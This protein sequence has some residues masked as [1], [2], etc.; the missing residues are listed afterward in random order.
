M[1]TSITVKATANGLPSGSFTATMT[2]PT[3]A[4]PSDEPRFETLRD[5]PEIS[6]WSAQGKLDW[7]TLTE[8]SA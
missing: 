4:V 6:P 3:I 7:T 1:I 8:E 2:E 5:N